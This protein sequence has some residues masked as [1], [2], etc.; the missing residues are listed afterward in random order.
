MSGAKVASRG[1]SDSKGL[2]VSSEPAR[3]SSLGLRLNIPLDLILSVTPSGLYEAPDVRICRHGDKFSFLITL[4][5]P[6]L[7]RVRNSGLRPSFKVRTVG[8]FELL[9]T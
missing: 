8:P 2:D 9:A 3:K 7:L 5:V 6:R 1:T 4:D